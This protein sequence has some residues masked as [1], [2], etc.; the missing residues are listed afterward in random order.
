MFKTILISFAQEIQSLSFTAVLGIVDHVIRT[1]RSHCVLDLNCGKWIIWMAHGHT[2]CLTYFSL[3]HFSRGSWEAQNCML[4]N[5]KYF[6][7]FIWQ[8]NLYENIWAEP[9]N[10]AIH[11]RAA[12]ICPQIQVISVAMWLIAWTLLCWINKASQNGLRL[13]VSRDEPW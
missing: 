6:R 12:W 11:R 2:S 9:M 10:L 7:W 4:Y 3:T 1:A 5:R 13:L 8:R